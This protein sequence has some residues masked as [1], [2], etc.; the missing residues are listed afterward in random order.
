MLKWLKFL[1][2]A[3][4]HDLIS[5]N[6]FPH[7]YYSNESEVIKNTVR[8]VWKKLKDFPSE[9][10]QSV[11]VEETTENSNSST[12]SSPQ[13]DKTFGI[14]QRLKELEKKLDS[15]QERRFITP[16]KNTEAFRLLLSLRVGKKK[17][18]KVFNKIWELPL[19]NTENSFAIF[20]PGS[21]LYNPS[22]YRLCNCFRLGVYL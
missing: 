20:P 10:S 7:S 6:Y 9:G 4:G 1:S 3:D 5:H 21:D 15:V 14:K 11:S 22:F 18:K 16:L 2:K 13:K 8:D 12:S 19:S 17:G